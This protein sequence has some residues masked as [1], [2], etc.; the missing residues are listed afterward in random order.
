ME[1]AASAAALQARELL[2]GRSGPSVTNTPTA[3]A[4]LGSANTTGAGLCNESAVAGSAA[5]VQ[6]EAQALQV[7]L[8]RCFAAP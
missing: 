4:A 7:H 8:A 3:S 6:Q 5:A 2:G 1:E